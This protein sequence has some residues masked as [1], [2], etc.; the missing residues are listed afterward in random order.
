V[1]VTEHL[2]NPWLKT[3]YRLVKE[4][5]VDPAGRAR[6]FHPEKSIDTDFLLLRKV[7]P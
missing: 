4:F 5:V 6:L 2:D 7:Q 1:D 3:D